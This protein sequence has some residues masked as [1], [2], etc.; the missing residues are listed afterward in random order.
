M[1]VAVAVAIPAGAAAASCPSTTALLPDTPAFGGLRA[2]KRTV[3]S[4][5]PSAMATGTKGA[6]RRGL[7]AAMR[8]NGFTSGAYRHYQRG[9][10]EALAF[11]KVMGSP[12]QARREIAYERRHLIAAGARSLDTTLDGAV[13]VAYRSAAGRTTATNIWLPVGNHVLFFGGY[14]R[15]RSPQA[16]VERELAAVAAQITAAC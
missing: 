13:G 15:A 4:A 5:Q 3:S 2:D 11:V 7:I 8:R 16:A 9:K 1:A 6:L 10:R 14:D 12:T